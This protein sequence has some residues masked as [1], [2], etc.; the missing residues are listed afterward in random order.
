MDNDTEMKSYRLH[1]ENDIDLLFTGR[2]LANVSSRDPNA[3]AFPRWTEIR[4]YRTE[5]GKY[6]VEQVGRSTV[7]NEVDRVTIKVA[8][9]A[10]EVPI[11][12]RRRDEVE[13]LTYL[14]LDALDLAASTDDEL[15]QAM[16]EKI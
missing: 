9:T 12:L 8:N 1:R 2:E 11:A 6:V 7:R 16:V 10:A 3:A 5:S 13:Y 14:A 4:I 15:A